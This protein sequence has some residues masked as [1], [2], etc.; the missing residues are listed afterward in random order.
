ME[1]QM[2]RGQRCL[3][4]L[5]GF[6]EA[7][8]VSHLPHANGHEDEGL[9]DGPP[10]HPLVGALTGLTEAL[11]SPLQERTEED[12]GESTEQLR[13]GAAKGHLPQGS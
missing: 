10:Q 12:G 3:H 11:F 8:E 1:A 4:Q 9:Q 7:L 2:A 13:L 5:L 6:E